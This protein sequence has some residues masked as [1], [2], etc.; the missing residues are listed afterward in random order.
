MNKTMKS[1][2]LVLTFM[3][4]VLITGCNGPKLELKTENNSN[5]IAQGESV[6]LVVNETG[7]VTYEVTKGSAVVNAT[8][9][10]TCSEEAEVGSRIEVVAT[11]ESGTAK[12]TLSVEQAKLKS[13]ELSCD[14]TEIKK[15]QK[16][17]LTTTLNPEYAKVE[18]VTYTVTKGSE[19]AEVVDGKLQIKESANQ[20]EII[21][22][23]I[24]VTA[25]TLETGLTDKVELTVVEAL[26]EELILASDAET[27]SYGKVVNL[28]VSYIPV[29][30]GGNKEYSLT[31]VE[32]IEIAELNGLE[33]RV[34]E[35]LTEAEIVGHVI[36]VK[37]VLNEN[38]QIYDEIEIRVVEAEQ[39]NIVVSDKTFVAGENAT[40]AL[41]PEAYDANFNL[42]DL[43]ATDFTYTSSNENVV[44]VGANDGKLTPVGH[45]SAQITVSYRNSSTTC[46]V[47]VIV[48]PEAI[49]F[50]G[51][52]THVLTSRRYYYA[53]HET[54]SFALDITPNENYARNDQNV[55]Y[56]FELL[57]E[58]GEVVNSGAE[59]ATISEG[60]ITFH[61]VGSVRVTV[62]TDSSL[63]GKNTASHEK[64]TSIV[65]NVNEGI[66][67]RTL[68][69]LI[70]YT[71]YSYRGKAA[72][73]IN[74]IK[75]DAEN[76]PGLDDALR[77]KTLEFEGDR[78]MY[79]NGYVIDL[80]DL[81]LSGSVGNSNDFLRFLVFGPENTHTLELRDLEVIGVCD[82]DG[83]Y[84]GNNAADK[85]KEAVDGS[86]K[87]GI[88]IGRVQQDGMGICTDLDVINVKVSG[89]NVG[90]RFEH[91]VDGYVSDIN[92]SQCA[93]NGMELNQNI[94]T[95]NNITVG[96][97]G[98]FAIEMTP[99]DMIKE[100]DGTIHGTS[101]LGFNEAPRTTLTGYINSTNYNNGKS[102]KYMESLQ[103]SGYTIPEILMMIVSQKIQYVAQMAASQTGMTVEQC[104]GYLADIAYRC[105]FKDADPS[106][107]LMNFF[108]LVFIDPT[109]EVFAGFT[110][111]NK[112]SIFGTYESGEEDGNVISIDQVLMDAA[113]TVIA[114]GT[115]DAYKNYKYILMDLDLTSAM[116]FNLGE[117]LVVNEYYNK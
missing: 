110:D 45:G 15:G 68:Q 105:L 29:F 16:V 69:D 52:S 11:S 67:I 111:G 46:E 100:A 14:S 66:N 81:P 50:S 5:K 117:V 19:F 2:L 77:Y 73:F 79:G 35:G 98:A 56:K 70:A 10:L 82:I 107:S 83:L 95:L 59:V 26:V 1:L 85:G 34:K 27:L 6:Q 12:L 86:Y 3:L 58:D 32:G 90:L 49:E 74:T 44:K 75:L 22:K 55:Q 103:L 65:V 72:N 99:D 84:V 20:A 63:N 88:R 101:G 54:L 25:T 33:L 48:V 8:G 115:Y 92:V 104:Q 28:N 114:G 30:A 36:R 109:E 18:G 40:E 13:I 80:L 4:I 62:T 60:A 21:G 89:F 37:A 39:I 31:I 87:R 51:L 7:A 112:N 91:V 94:I 57:N 41:L 17:V 96:Q 23:T 102:T 9:L 24:E 43:D 108:L 61:T 38:A 64:S 116:G 93:S 76:N 47:F 71:D 106:Q 78:Y 53:K 97:V 113:K 42:M